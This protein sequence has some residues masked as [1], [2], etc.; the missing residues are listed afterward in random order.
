MT[1]AGFATNQGSYPMPSNPSHPNVKTLR[2]IYAN[3]RCIGEYVDDDVVL[4]SAEREITGMKAD[5]VGRQEVVEKE[6]ELIRLSGDTLVMDVQSIQA[7]DHFGTV[8]GTLR[9]YLRGRDMAEPFCGVWQFRDGR[10]I[11][12]WE[13]AYDARAVGRFLM[14]E[15]IA[16]A[17]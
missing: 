9:A 6:Q 11:E 2:A 14:G 8:I 15:D 12:H 13:N 4:H 1:G 16:T 5:Y 17:P 10:V 7:N 3:L